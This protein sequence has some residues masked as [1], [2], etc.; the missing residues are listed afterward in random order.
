MIG[1]DLLETG[2]QMANRRKKK[3]NTEFNAVHPT[4]NY[5]IHPS[6]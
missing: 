5:G 4:V 1:Y 2:A 6:A 3:D